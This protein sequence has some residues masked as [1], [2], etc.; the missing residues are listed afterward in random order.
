MSIHIDPSRTPDKPEGKKAT[1]ESRARGSRQSSAI[2]PLALAP[3]PQVKVL[4]SLVLSKFPVNIQTA[5]NSPERP[6]QGEHRSGDRLFRDWDYFRIGDDRN[7]LTERGTE[8]AI[9][10]RAIPPRRQQWRERETD[11]IFA[12]YSSDKPTKTYL[13]SADDGSSPQEPLPDDP[14]PQ[15]DPKWSPDGDKYSLCRRTG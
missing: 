5:V 7:R 2:L 8:I 13:V 9:N 14:E 4:E 12:D 11:H 15:R 10:E 3:I 1:K 6:V